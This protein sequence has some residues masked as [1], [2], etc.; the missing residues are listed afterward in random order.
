MLTVNQLSPNLFHPCTSE[1]RHASAIALVALQAY[2]A[3]VKALV[4]AAVN[5][6]CADEEG[7]F[8][9]ANSSNSK[10][11]LTSLRKW[12][13]CSHPLSYQDRAFEHLL[14]C[15]VPNPEDHSD[16]LPNL[17]KEQL[18][19][20]DF[21]L[22]IISMTQPNKPSVVT[23][24]LISSAPSTTVFRIAVTYM[25]KY[26][27]QHSSRAAESFMQDAFSGA[28]NH[29][30]INHV[31]WHVA[32]TG[33]RG[34]RSRTP[35]HT[36]WVNLGKASGSQTM[37][38]AKA[39]Q[40]NGAAEASKKAQASDARA[41]WAVQSITLQSLPQ[42]ISRDSLPDEFCLENIDIEKGEKEPL[43][44]QIYEWVFTNFNS[45]KPIHKIALLAGIYISKIL[46]DIFTDGAYNPELGDGGYAITQALRAL[47]WNP[48]RSTRKG[49]R[50][51]NQFI[52]MVPAYI[53]AVYE[54]E[55]PLRRYFADRQG[56]SFPQRWNSKNS[57]KGIGSLL[58]IRLGLANAKGKRIWKGGIFNRDWVPLTVE[59]LTAKYH[60]INTHLSDLQYG[61]FKIAV[62]FFGL[63][64]AIELGRMSQ[65]YTISPAMQSIA[66][67]KRLREVAKDED[68]D[69]DDEVEII[70]HEKGKRARL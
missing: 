54:P 32:N 21:S 69:D 48:N 64:K 33:A 30:H 57:N 59:E 1:L 42:F 15:I 46:P 55:S 3:D 66:S 7:D 26:A 44:R 67:H 49:C 9:I 45:R 25:L 17:S 34:R 63:D 23:A 36:S 4:A 50:S 41:P 52:A 58:M 31:P 65:T 18:T 5:K 39:R 43:I 8:G 11:R 38:Q 70:E 20:R 2:I 35:V 47:P 12:L 27:P 51:E 29:L 37:S 14:R 56:K 53:I 19:I 68:D 10:S 60:E 61:P 62:A 13:S 28:A 16:G 6:E 24:P 40:P 22:R